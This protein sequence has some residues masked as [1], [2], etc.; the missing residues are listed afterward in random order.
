MERLQIK[1]I[2]FVP[3]HRLLRQCE[4]LFPHAEVRHQPAV[5]LRNVSV[6][7]LLKTGLTTHSNAAAIRMGRR[8]HHEAPSQGAIGLQHAN[9][10]AL[11]DD[12][13]RPLLLLEDDCVLKDP[14]RLA[15][16]V[17]ALAKREAE[18]DLAAFGVFYAAQ[19]TRTPVEFLPEG[20]V[21]AKDMF[22]GLHCVLY[23]SHGRKLLA[24]QLVHPFDMQIDSLY[25]SLARSGVVRCCIELSHHTARQSMHI[26]TVQT[27]LQGETSGLAAA[28]P[29]LVGLLAGALALPVAR[30]IARHPSGRK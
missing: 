13:T 22:W 16:C 9:R 23:S 26:S 20:W 27:R 11:S 12:V 28:T 5:D 1:V 2:A 24:E 10:L 19:R 30:W 21:H 8:W 17:R 14:Q 18:F 4:R 29:F 15:L 25:G 6:D 3:N 7:D